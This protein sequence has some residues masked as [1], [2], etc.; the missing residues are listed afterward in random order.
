M[1]SAKQR[2]RIRRVASVVVAPHSVSFPS[3]RASLHVAGDSMVSAM[4]RAAPSLKSLYKAA[5][6]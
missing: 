5:P 4:D 6:G 2:H 3:Q 1:R